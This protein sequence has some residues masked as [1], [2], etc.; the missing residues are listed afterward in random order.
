MI[1]YT[2]HALDEAAADEVRATLRAPGYG[3][4][5]HAETATDDAPCRVC[6]TRFTPGRDRRILFTHDPFAGTEPFP[7]PGPVFVHADAC[8]PYDPDARLPETLARGALTFNAYAAGRRLL[9]VERTHGPDAAAAAVEGLL[10]VPG[11]AAI[12]VR[13]T[14]AGCF[15]CRIERAAA[16]AAA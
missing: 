10:G 8:R 14:L 15:L 6:L 7:L 11:I 16:A 2:V 12:H 5:A 4:A 1:P 13:S 3:H 9:A